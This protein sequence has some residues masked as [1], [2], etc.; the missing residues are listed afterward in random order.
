MGV[1]L[2]CTKD[3]LLFFHRVFDKEYQRKPKTNS[4]LPKDLCNI[5]DSRFAG[6]KRIFFDCQNISGFSS[7]IFTLRFLILK[8][9]CRFLSI[10]LANENCETLSALIPSH[11]LFVFYLIFSP[12]SSI[13]IGS[14]TILPSN[15]GSVR[16]KVR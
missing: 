13:L 4:K 11:L 16:N 2:T 9:Q 6:A 10:R 12:S 1:T 5:H 8:L 15:L 14:T 7:K 3:R